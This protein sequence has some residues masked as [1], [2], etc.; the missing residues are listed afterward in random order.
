MQVTEL[1][2]PI[3]VRVDFSSGGKVTPRLFT[4]GPR[5]FRVKRVNTRWEDRD[6][7]YKA[8]RLTVTVTESDDV[9]QLCFREKDLTWVLE[10][11]MLPG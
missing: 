5:T 8:L 7:N 11:V 1:N 3:K 9:F 4:H 6:A 2:D 10:K